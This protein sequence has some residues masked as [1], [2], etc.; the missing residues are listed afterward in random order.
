ML[1]DWFTVGAQA[2]NFIILVWLLK[3]FLYK[4]ILDAVYARDD[5]VATELQD[6]SANRADATQGGEPRH[7]DA[8][9]DQVFRWFSPSRTRA[10]RRVGTSP[11]SLVPEVAEAT[12][13]RPRCTRPAMRQVRAPDAPD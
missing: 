12:A 5:R 10:R 13:H 6:A 9:G 11:A 1:I 7:Q 2:L 8:D 4:P 3:R